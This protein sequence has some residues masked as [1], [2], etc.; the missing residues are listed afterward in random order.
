MILTDEQTAELEKN[1]PPVKYPKIGGLIHAARKA[2]RI[3]QLELAKKLGID[4][5]EMS[6]IEHGRKLPTVEQLKKMAA[7]FG[8]ESSDDN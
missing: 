8:A 7:I 1:L 5:T 6:Y 3:T 2:K 4:Y